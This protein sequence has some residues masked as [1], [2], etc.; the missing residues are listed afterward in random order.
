MYS[1]DRTVFKIQTFDQSAHTKEYWLK[2]APE[3]RW[4]AAWYL[5]CSAYGIDYQNPP[6]L[7]RS[8]FAARKNG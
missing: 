7:D 2:Q 8:Q 3:E 5:I 6:R 1:L 4:K